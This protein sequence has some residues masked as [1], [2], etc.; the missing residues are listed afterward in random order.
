MQCKKNWDQVKTDK[1]SGILNDPNAW[2]DDPRYILD[3]VKR[4]VRVSLETLRTVV[5]LPNIH[6]VTHSERL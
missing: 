4:V 1:D 6:N 2:S 3:L 5:E